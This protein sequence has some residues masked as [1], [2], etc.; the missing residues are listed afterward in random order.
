MLAQLFEH[1]SGRFVVKLAFNENGDPVADNLQP[2]IDVLAERAPATVRE[3]VLGDNVDQISWHHTGNLARL[4]NGVPNLRVLAIETGDV[5][6]GTIDAPALERMVVKTGG[7]S[8][9]A[10]ASLAALRAPKLEHLEIYYGD[11]EYG[12]DCSIADVAPLLAR[13]DLP[14]LRELGLKNAMFETD[15]ARAVVE[16]KLLGQLRA[17]DLSLGT[18]TDEGAHVLAASRDALA[19]LDTLDLS[20][21]FLTADGIAAVRGLARHVITEDQQVAED[22]LYYVAVQE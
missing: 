19:H 16:S 8:K 22:E 15:I 7:L 9:A 20:H 2:L 21:N 10:G 12:G 14:A 13:T 4:W 18:M 17:L 1:P 6:F 3:I 5:T 11:P